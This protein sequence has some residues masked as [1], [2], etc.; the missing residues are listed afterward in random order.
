MTRWRSADI[1]IAVA[2]PFVVG[3]PARLLQ[4]RYKL[5]Q[6]LGEG[7]MGTVWRCFDEELEEWVAIKFLRE[8]LAR[9]EMLRGL[10]RREVRLARKVTHRNVARVNEFGR[11]GDLYF[12]TME[13]IAGESLQRQL[14]REGSLTPA[15]VY[16]RAVGLCKGMAAAHAVG[17][18]HGDLKPA[19]VLLAP[20]RGAVLTDFGIARAL[21]EGPNHNELGLGTPVYMAP[22]QIAGGP[23][24]T[25]SDVYA[26]GVLLFEALTGQVPWL[27]AD[28]L[29]L[30]AEKASGRPLALDRGAPDLPA[31][32]RELLTACMHDDPGQRPQDGRA[33]LARLGGLSEGG[34]EPARSLEA[35]LGPGS[36]SG[37][38]QWLADAAFTGEEEEVRLSW[39][40]GD[41]VDALTQVRGADAAGEAAKS[42]RS[43]GGE[44]TDAG[45]M[46]SG[47]G[48]KPT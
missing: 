34:D 27:A 14:A 7:G 35:L 1:V 13:Y 43:S 45:A 6:R 26:A 41:L 16:A 3:A 10:F 11:D 31:Q 25:Q 9:D 23:M 39:M 20:G 12:L 36:E 47:R 18:V 15:R 37:A 33:L 8:E 40:T 32:W 29:S 5:G 24:T 19:N 21:A 42:A 38:P 4:G 2:T 48:P 44:G 28:V 17:V 22:E 30:L 46:G